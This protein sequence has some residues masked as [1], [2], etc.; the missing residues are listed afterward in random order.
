[1]C[2]ISVKTESKLQQSLV[3]FIIE[4]ACI[5]FV[6]A[7]STVCQ[8]SAYTIFVVFYMVSFVRTLYPEGVIADLAVNIKCVKITM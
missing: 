8:H 2:L 4:Q 1:M 5:L 3:S 6:E 7:C